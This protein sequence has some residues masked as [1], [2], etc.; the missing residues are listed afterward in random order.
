MRMTALQPR[1]VGLLCLAATSFG[2]GINWPA[3]KLLL[4][5]WPPLFARGTSG[6]VASMIIG[7]IAVATGQGLRVPRALLPRLLAASLLNVF[8]WMGF[9]NLALR[10]LSAGQ[11]ALLVYTMPVWATLIAWLFLGRRPAWSSVLGL[12]VC[13]SGVFILFGGTGLSLDTG[14]LPGVLFALA[15]AVL[16]AFGTVVLGPLPLPPFTA[17]AW[18]LAFG[19]TPMVVLGL[20]FES[21]QF[22]ALTM[23]GG[24]VMVYMTL[25]PMGICYLA[26]FAAL[27]R[28]PPATASVTA[29]MT[30]VIGVLAAAVVLDEALGI[31]EVTALLLT[32]GGVALVQRAPA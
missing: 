26:W 6:L 4:L 25:V 9:S 27:R 28:L 11:G 18:Q 15:A 32:L 13:L 21:P 31:R 22:G 10:W 3:M 2:W 19:C 30:P 14:M 12:V 8:A 24:T 1:T 17:L 20:L 29:L 7:L 5:E 23:V 16:F